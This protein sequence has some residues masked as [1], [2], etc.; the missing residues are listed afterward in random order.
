MLDS[1]YYSSGTYRRGV[2]RDSPCHKV[3]YDKLSIID[4]DTAEVYA[5][6]VWD[7]ASPIADMD[8]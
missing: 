7:N 8:E 3:H 1:T 4:K 2:R 6:E 5:E